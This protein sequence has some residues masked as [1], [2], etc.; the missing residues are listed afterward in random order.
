MGIIRVRNCMFRLTFDSLLFVIEFD[1]ALR[2]D[3]GDDWF[4]FS[5]YEYPIES[6]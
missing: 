6:V 4:K 5:I 2:N 3:F 1:F